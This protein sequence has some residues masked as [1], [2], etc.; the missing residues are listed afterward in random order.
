MSNDKKIFVYILGVAQDGGYPHA[1]CKKECCNKAWQDKALIKHPSSI[2]IVNQKLKKYWLIDVTPDIKHQI[3]LLDRFNCKLSGIFITHAHFGHYAGLFNL[4]LEVM[5]LKKVPVYVMPRMKNFIITNSVTRQL[6]DNDNI[7][8]FDLYDNT[9]I[10]LEEG[11]S[12]IPFNVPHRNELS[13][14]VGFKIQTKNKS[15]IYLPDIDSWNNWEENLLKLIN[16]NDLLFIDGTFYSE[17]E[18]N[19]R[20]ISKI[21][22]PPIKDTMKRLS[23]LNINDRNKIYFTHLNHTNPV[24]TEGRTEYKEV[25]ENGFFIL[26]ELERFD[27]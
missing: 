13:E 8:L 15:I 14:T 12:I 18:I 19:H 21:P 24:I 5:N 4:G 7:E 2:A 9:N 6:L 26:K 25:L 22:H 16:Q 27:L 23:I 3:H 20:N 10:E 11:I 1:N 17:N